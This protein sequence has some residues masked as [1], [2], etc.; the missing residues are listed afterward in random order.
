MTMDV[1]DCEW[2]RNCQ[3][4]RCLGPFN[5]L[6]AWAMYTPTVYFGI[7]FINI[8]LYVEKVVVY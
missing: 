1:F 4:L 8:A 2:L 7:R 3:D 6:V 5:R